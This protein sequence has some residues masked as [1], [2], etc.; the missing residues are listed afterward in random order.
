LNDRNNQI[1]QGAIVNV[2][3]GTVFVLLIAVLG[4][5]VYKQLST[6][7]FCHRFVLALSLQTGESSPELG[8]QEANTMTEQLLP[9]VI[10]FDTYREPVLEY[11]EENT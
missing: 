9:P 1:T 7:M 8:P 4:Y 6:S 2:S 11:E 3:V 10:H 5:Q